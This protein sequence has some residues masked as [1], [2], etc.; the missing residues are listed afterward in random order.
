[1]TTKLCCSTSLSHLLLLCLW[2]G[3]ELRN[4]CV[5]LTN[6]DDGRRETGGGSPSVLTPAGRSSLNRAICCLRDQF[7][8]N[9]QRVLT[10]RLQQFWLIWGCKCSIR[11]E[12]VGSYLRCFP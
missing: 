4:W 9:N 12:T 2:A 6:R 8:L 7:V 3:F 5:G 11:A 1:L 10:G